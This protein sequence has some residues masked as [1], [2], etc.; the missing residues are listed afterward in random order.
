MLHHYHYEALRQLSHDRRRA[1]L[2]RGR[3]L[4]RQRGQV[5]GSLAL[6]LSYQAML[7]SPRRHGL[8][9]DAQSGSHPAPLEPA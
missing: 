6:D 8:G 4:R 7:R 1:L 2:V 9:M 5:D 3:R